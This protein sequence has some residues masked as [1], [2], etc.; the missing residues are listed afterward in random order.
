MQTTDFL[1]DVNMGEM[2]N[3]NSTGV[4]KLK[5]FGHIKHDSCLE[6]IAMKDVVP[7]Q[8][9]RAN[10]Q[11]DG[12]RTLRTPVRQEDWQPSAGLLDGP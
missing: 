4:W 2:W 3:I 1:Y 9:S 10:L 11:G 8:R 12:Q 5:S 6:M 7:W